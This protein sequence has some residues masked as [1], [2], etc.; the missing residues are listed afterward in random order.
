MHQDG[1]SVPAAFL[2]PGLIHCPL[3]S[4]C[5]AWLWCLTWPVLPP[6]GRR[7]QRPALCGHNRTACGLSQQ[8]QEQPHPLLLTSLRTGTPEGQAPARAGVWAAA[9]EL[10]RAAAYSLPTSPHHCSYPWLPLLGPT[11]WRLQ[12]C[13]PARASD[14]S[15]P[16]IAHVYGG[17]ALVRGLC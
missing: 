3:G 1:Q 2:P 10:G 15:L 13:S 9:A 16:V 5:S 6:C 12:S 11:G 14:S 17:R 4:V 8:S 7:S